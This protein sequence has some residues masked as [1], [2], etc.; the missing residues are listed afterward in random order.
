MS[1]KTLCCAVMGGALAMGAVQLMG[2]GGDDCAPGRQT[3]CACPAGQSGVQVCDSEGVFGECVCGGEGGTGGMGGT[4][5]TMMTTTTT[6]MGGSGGAPC[7]APSMVCDGECVDVTSSDAHCGMC[8]APCPANISCVDSDCACPGTQA[9]CDSVCIDTQTDDANCGGCD[10][11]CLGANCVGGICDPETLATPGGE[12]YSV[13]V[14]ATSIYFSVGGTVNKVYRADIDGSNLVEVDTAQAKPREIALTSDALFWSNFGISTDAS[15]MHLPLSSSD[16]PVALVSGQNMGLWGIAVESDYVYFANQED[17]TVSRKSISMATGAQ[18]LASAQAR[19]WDVAVDATHVY[20]TNY[21]SGDL[22]RTPING[23]Q[24]PQLIATGQGNPLGIAIDATHV[25]WSTDTAGEIKRASLTGGTAE[26]LASSLSQPTYVA[27]DATHVYWTNFGNGTVSK[28][29]LAGG[30]VINLAAGQN[31]P[32]GIAVD[33]THVYWST[34]A[35]QTVMR[36][37]K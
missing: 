31:K 12:V 30:T 24:V 1:I 5:G 22:R 34:L 16:P 25:Y 8:N 7:D 20:W 14:N 4:G 21:D 6:S 11:D 2:C 18:L 9:L 28:V 10:H 32:Y 29:P 33:T 27:L 37:P 13:A 26:V 36:A 15:V 17:N 19:P 3:S 23:G 35:G